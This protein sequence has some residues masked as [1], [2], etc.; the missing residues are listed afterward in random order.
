M[1]R[2]VARD[3]TTAAFFD[4]ASDGVFLLRQSVSSGEILPPHVEQDGVGNTDLTWIPASGTGVVVS[5]AFVPKC[6]TDEVI[7]VGIV[8]LDEGPWWWTQLVDVEPAALF[9]GL[10]VRAVFPKSG[11]ADTDEYVPVF[12]PAPR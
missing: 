6:G 1:I 2:P 11:T 8:E 3:T 5:W 9:E 10:R 7:I 12:T 4:A